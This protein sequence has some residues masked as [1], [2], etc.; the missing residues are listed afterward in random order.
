LFSKGQFAS[1]VI[2]SDPPYSH[3]WICNCIISYYWIYDRWE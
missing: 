2:G 3:A 1:L